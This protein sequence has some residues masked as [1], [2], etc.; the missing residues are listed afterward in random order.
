MSYSVNNEDV[1]KCD[2]IHVHEDIVKE[3]LGNMPEEENLYD[4]GQAK[5]S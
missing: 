4:L 3:V 5:I 1:E 2:F